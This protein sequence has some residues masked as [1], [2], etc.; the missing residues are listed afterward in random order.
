MTSL[1]LA[2]G[3]TGSL[4]EQLKQEI[5]RRVRNG[6][7]RPGDRLPSAR[8]LAGELGIHRGTV[9]AAYSELAEDGILASHVG[10]GTFVTEEA[11]R[12]LPAASPEGGTFRWRDHF[13]GFEP[14]PRVA[15]IETALARSGEPGMISFVRNIP[16]EALFP[17]E[18]FRKSLN[19]V[20]REQGGA[21]LSYAAPEGHDVFL[22]FVREYLA[23]ERG[24]G[25]A[26]DQL[27]IVNGSQQAMDLIARTFLRPG[28]TVLVEEPSYSGALDLFRGHGA[29]F[30][31]VPVDAEGILVEEMEPVLARERPKLIYLMPTFQNPTGGC[32]SPAR[33]HEVVRLSARY[34]VP[35]V[36][37]DFDGELWFDEPPPPP[38][39]S[40]PGSEGVL[41]I[42][43]PSKMLFPGLRIGWIA[44]EAPVVRRLSRVR[45][46]ADLSGSPLLQAA[47]ARFAST[48]ALL[49]HMK[50]V[51][52]AYG[53]RLEKL[54]EALARDMPPGITW[55]TPRGGLSLL[56]SL[57]EGLDSGDLLRDAAEEGVLFTPGQMFFVNDG[58]RHLRLSF[59]SVPTE[60]VGEGAKRLARAVRRALGRGPRRTRSR[61]G[62]SLPTV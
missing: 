56:V 39:K 52:R 12:I 35:V 53:E 14:P 22:E 7:L 9:A 36:E 49:R 24:V 50:M 23:R 3:G 45:R 34:E 17:A 6:V 54:L 38:L 8:G 58:A 13:A 47:L 51:R 46:V 33:R 43:T 15:E 18:A 11:A 25:M 5:E 62:L 16:D 26:E 55:T 31:S 37:D 44:A 48:G 57:P 19:E 30:V 60:K 27:L 29:R 2:P 61:G 1:R 21:L 10:R 32:L 28:D 4:V 40:I 20:L 41:Y 42:G 59:G